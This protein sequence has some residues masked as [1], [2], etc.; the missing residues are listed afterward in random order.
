MAFLDT[1]FTGL[2]SAPVLLSVGIVLGGGNHRE[3][4]AEVV[5]ADRLGAAASFTVRNVLPQ[6]G[7]IAGAG[8]LY[9][10]LV[11]RLRAFLLDLAPL[12][13]SGKFVEI[14]F[15]S[16]I[17]W[18]L[19]QQALKDDHDL[20]LPRIAHFIRPVNIYNMLGFAAGE[21]AAD[22]YYASQATSPVHRHHA[23]CDARALRIAYAAASATGAP[24]R[25]S[26][27]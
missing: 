5:D 2:G 15:N 22:D 7:Y 11:V 23:L 20:S 6:F 3:F 18:M 9:V 19:I 12:R 27:S 24:R 13:E 4:Y 10:E 21:A 26:R 1:E 8:C 17:D 14:A 25:S 16:D